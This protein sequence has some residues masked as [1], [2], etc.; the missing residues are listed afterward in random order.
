MSGIKDLQMY[1]SK[2]EEKG[3]LAIFEAGRSLRLSSFRE[4][5]DFSFIQDSP[6]SFLILNVPREWIRLIRRYTQTHTHAHIRKSVLFSPRPW[7]RASKQTC[8]ET[9]CVEAPSWPMDG[10]SQCPSYSVSSSSHRSCTHL[11]PTLQV[12]R[13]SIYTISRPCKGRNSFNQRSYAQ[14]AVA[15][16]DTMT[17]C[18][19]TRVLMH[20]QAVDSG[21]ENL[22]SPTFL[23]TS[24][25][26]SIQSI[27]PRLDK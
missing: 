20:S 8:V 10:A 11:G 14:R 3:T 18:V 13:T 6:T 19:C 4:S 7:Q 26:L 21:L 22:L 23:E 24:F 9:T 15:A 5:Q 27:L 2:I 25:L 12:V 16:L 17:V 1:A